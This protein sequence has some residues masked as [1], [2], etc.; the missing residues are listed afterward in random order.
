[1]NNQLHENQINLIYNM[2]CNYLDVIKKVT[3]IANIFREMTTVNIKYNMKCLS[4]ECLLLS[5]NSRY[6]TNLFAYD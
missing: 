1:M 4:W 3:C 5:V 6:Y 2:I